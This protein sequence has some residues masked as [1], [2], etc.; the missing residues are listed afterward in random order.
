MPGLPFVHMLASLH[1]TAFFTD[2]LQ[3]GDTKI[4]LLDVYL[5]HTVHESTAQAQLH[6]DVDVVVILEDPLHADPMS[7]MP[8]TS[9]RGQQQT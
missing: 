8:D 1:A 9:G 2:M 5:L 4:A 6:D 3:Q 7:G